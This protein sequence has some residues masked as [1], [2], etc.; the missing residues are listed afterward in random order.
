LELFKQQRV[1]KMDNTNET[2]N[3]I[4]STIGDSLSNLQKKNLRRKIHANQVQPLAIKGYGHKLATKGVEIANQW[5]QSGLRR[6]IKAHPVKATGLILLTG[7]VIHSIFSSK[8]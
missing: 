6:N 2:I 7:L 3:N 8:D 4:S 1:I 5:Q